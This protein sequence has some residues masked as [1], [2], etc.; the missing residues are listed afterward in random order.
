MH[1]SEEFLV[2]ERFDKESDRSD[3]HSGGARGQI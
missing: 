1:R 2:V 3:L